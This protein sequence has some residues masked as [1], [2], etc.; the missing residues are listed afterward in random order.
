MNVLE[1]TNLLWHWP[2]LET[3][4]RKSIKSRLK[5]ELHL[6]FINLKSFGLITYLF[7]KII[8]SNRWLDLST[9]WNLY[10]WRWYI[11]SRAYFLFRRRTIHHTICHKLTFT[12]D[13]AF[14]RKTTYWHRLKVKALKLDINSS[15][16][17]WLHVKCLHI[18]AV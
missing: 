6:Y 4:G 11:Y 18:S 8:T 10:I 13:Q 15:R 12:N 7:F 14:D 1:M 5:I 17:L 9:H 16:V 2:L 3:F